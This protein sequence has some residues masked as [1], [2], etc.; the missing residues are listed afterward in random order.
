M[1]LNLPKAASFS[2]PAAIWKRAV[3]FIVDLVILD[4]VFGFVLKSKIVTVPPTEFMNVISFYENNPQILYTNTLVMLVYGILI[5]AYF[6]ILEYKIGQTIGKIFMSI[7]VKPD[8]KTQ[9]YFS[10]IVRSMY[11]IFIFPFFLM[12][13]IDPIYLIFNKENRRLTEVLSKTRTVE[14]YNLGG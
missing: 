2:G 12:W 6:S 7:T 4:I 13:A 8:K 11:F 10:Y 9:G 3:A 14:K 5:L 1:K